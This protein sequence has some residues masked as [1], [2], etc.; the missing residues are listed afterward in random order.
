MRSLMLGLIALGLGCA[1]DA[2]AQP[3]I[4]S[5]SREASYGTLVA[6][7]GFGFD[8]PTVVFRGYGPYGSCEH[9][10]QVQ[11]SSDRN[12]DCRIYENYC[13]GKLDLTITNA[14]GTSVTETDALL[15]VDG[16]LAL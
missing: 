5:C 9:R 16:T 11:Y 3:S 13:F 7:T 1:A 14:D 15:F 4:D 6:I 10:C 12:I 8:D 2:A